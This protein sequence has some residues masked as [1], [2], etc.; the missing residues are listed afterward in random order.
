M[1]LTTT[2][3]SEIL[4]HHLA[5]LI[6]GDI[7]ELLKDYTEGSSVW[8]ADAEFNGLEAIAA[9]FREV[10]KI[11]PKGTTRLELQR[12]IIKDDIAYVAWKA[13]SPFADI[14]AAADTF[15]MKNDKI[16]VQAI[17][18]HIIPKS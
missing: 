2:R 5:A 1:E 7:D 3:T 4:N 18:A 14:P 16:S 17:G 11:L 9:F 13:D 12:T 6:E 8:T 10:F 15:I